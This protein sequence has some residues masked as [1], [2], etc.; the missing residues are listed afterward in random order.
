[1]RGQG[2]SKDVDPA[3]FWNVP[4]NA[5]NVKGNPKKTTIE[6]SDFNKDTYYPA[7]VNDIAAVKAWLDR[8]N[9]GGA[10]NTSS[11][12]LIGAGDGATLGAIWQRS[13]WDLY[14][15]IPDPNIAALTIPNSTP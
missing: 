14:R 6:L 5:K 11:T 9:D 15:G 13:Q 4:F 1:F 12:I 8:K 2:K 3:K 7:M 10:C